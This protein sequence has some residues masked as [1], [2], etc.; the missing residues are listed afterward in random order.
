MTS[1][2][3]LTKLVSKQ[4]LYFVKEGNLRQKNAEVIVSLVVLP[5][6]QRQ[7]LLNT[8]Y[9]TRMMDEGHTFDVFYLDCATIFPKKRDCSGIRP[10]HTWY[11]MQ[12]CV[13]H[14]GIKTVGQT[15]IW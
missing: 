12:G 13:V 15:P 5:V 3:I 2:R 14:R 4:E 10:A 9:M 6:V 7:Y 11:R 1:Q 8:N